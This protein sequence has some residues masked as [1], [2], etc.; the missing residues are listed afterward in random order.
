MLQV[1]E[2]SQGSSPR[3]VKS[4]SMRF[5]TSIF[6]NQRSHK[7][8]VVAKVWTPPWDFYFSVKPGSPMVIGTIVSLG[9]IS[10]WIVAVGSC[11]TCTK[12]DCSHLVLGVSRNKTH[13]SRLQC[14]GD[15]QREGEGR[16]SSFSDLRP[17]VPKR[18]TLFPPWS[19]S[20]GPVHRVRR[21]PD[22]P[23]G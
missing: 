23:G 8:L 18:F 15:L 6:V 3:F 5:R 14:F 11:R 4:F 20:P 13:H 19:W 21:W 10:L 2:T 22:D 9:C 16:H 1:A 12:S 7:G 17:A